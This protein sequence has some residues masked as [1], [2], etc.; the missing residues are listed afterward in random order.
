MG[1]N[2]KSP[3]E[4]RLLYPHLEEYLIIGVYLIIGIPI[5]NMMKITTI[6]IMIT[7]SMKTMK[8]KMVAKVVLIH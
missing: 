5:M 3:L 1:A 4:M 8:K 2:M 7:M 6:L